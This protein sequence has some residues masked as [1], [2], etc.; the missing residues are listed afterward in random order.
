M[1]VVSSIA[2]SLGYLGNFKSTPEQ[3]RFPLAWLIVGRLHDFC[4]CVPLTY[5]Q[6]HPA[7]SFLVNL[8]VL[9]SLAAE[10]FIL[11]HSK[12][13]YTR[14]FFLPCVW[15]SLWFISSRFGILGDY[16]SFSTSLIQ[17]AEFS[18]AA[19]LGGRALLDFLAVLTGTI[20]FELP[21]YPLNAFTTPTASTLL[22][23]SSVA[24]DEEDRDA[25]ASIPLRRRQRIEFLIHPVTIY[26]IIMLAIFTFGGISVNIRKGSFYQTAYPDFIPDTAPVG[27]VVGANELVPDIKLNHTIWFDK[28]SQLVQVCMHVLEHSKLSIVIK[29]SLYRLVPNSSSGLN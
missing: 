14:V 18:Q 19:S 27:C 20:L 17:W 29:Q 12:Y 5:S 16:P 10:R 11:T 4:F 7:A 25:R 2:V 22:V 26:S 13:V 1:Y 24:D 15:T 23:N 8:L 21:S 9:I 3:V 6:L 28:S